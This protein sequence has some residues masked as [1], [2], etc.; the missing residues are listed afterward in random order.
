[1]SDTSI[2]LVRRVV[3]G[4]DAEGL[5]TVISDGAAPN[6]MVSSSIRG[7]GAAHAW[8]ETAGDISNEGSD[9]RGSAATK[10]PMHPELGGSIFRVVDFPP[11][12]AYPEVGKD[13][14]FDEIGGSDARASATA[15]QDKHFWFH[16]TDSID[17]AIVLEGEISLLLDK[18][19]TLLQ[20]GDVVVQRG[21][22]HSWVNRSGKACR[23]AFV[24]IG[25]EPV[26]A[27]KLDPA[28]LSE[29]LA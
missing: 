11:D 2:G 19:E 22:A 24:L 14:L 29:Q 5:S 12:E 10:I 27:P 6:R 21:T 1:M 28:P 9:D 8:Y 4:T 18:D 3:T 17:Y 13:A 20:A 25:A 26:R 16:K 23:M 15:S 7:F